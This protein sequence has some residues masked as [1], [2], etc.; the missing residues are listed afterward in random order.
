MATVDKLLIISLIILCCWFSYT[1]IT[2]RQISNKLTYPGIIVLLVFRMMCTAILV[3]MIPGAVLLLV[4][5]I[6]PR[7]LGTSNV[8]LVGLLGLGV[9][10]EQAVVA[11]LLMCFLFFC[12][13]EEE[14]CCQ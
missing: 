4:F 5:M 12:I 7:S 1:D 2:E 10:L 6:S 14:S 13:Q 11:L 3:G 9:G 8:K